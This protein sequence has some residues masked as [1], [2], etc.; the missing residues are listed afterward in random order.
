MI[1]SGIAIR[2]S[3][4]SGHVWTLRQ[5]PPADALARL[6]GAVNPLPN[7]ERTWTWRLRGVRRSSGS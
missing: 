3:N 5:F 6:F 1:Q 4:L 2:L 7:L